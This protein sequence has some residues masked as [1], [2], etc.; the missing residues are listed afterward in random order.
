MD[1]YSNYDFSN[2]ANYSTSYSDGLTTTSSSAAMDG[3]VLM[4]MLV[5]SGIVFLLSIVTMVGMWKAFAKAGKPGWAAIVPIYNNI[6]QL[7]IAGRPAWWVLLTMFVPIFGVWVAIVALIDLAK[8]YGK[9]GGFAALLILVPI[10]GWLI[11]GFG[12]DK[13][14]GPVAA[15]RTDFMP[16]PGAPVAYAQPVAPQMP[17]A[18]TDAAPVAPV[19]PVANDQ[20][21]TPPQNPQV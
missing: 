8:S 17:N 6:V 1:N 7:E 5:V 15:G 20:Q 18:A 9:S 14:L 2:Y 3:A 21:P 4:I 16:A 13:Y 10:V 12:K 11:L 19:T